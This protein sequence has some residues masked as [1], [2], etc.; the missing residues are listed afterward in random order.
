ME[1][2]V[3]P[4]STILATS[5]DGIMELDYMDQ[6]LLEGCWLEAPGSDFSYPISPFEPSFPWPVL[7]SG[8]GEASAAG[9]SVQSEVSNRWWFGPTASTSV[10]DRLVQALGY[11]KE[12]SSSGEGGTLV[13][14]WV[15]VTREGRRVL[16]T[17]EQPFSLDLNCTRLAH[18]REISVKYLFPAEESESGEG[19]GLPGRVFRSKVPEWTPDVRF[20]TRDEYPRVRHAQQVDVRGTLAVPVLEQGSRNCLGVIEVV[21]TTQK[22]QYRPELETVCKALEV[23]LL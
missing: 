21:L 17:S 5:A 14:V 18:Y 13:Q 8:T 4:L 22:L 2:G 3:V 9:S 7:E 15:P 12:C 16:T 10:M 19:V 1:E 11:I 20:F 23:C 6:L